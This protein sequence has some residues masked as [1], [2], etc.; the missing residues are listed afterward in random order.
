MVDSAGIREYVDRRL[1]MS[2]VRSPDEWLWNGQRRRIDVAVEKQHLC[3]VQSMLCQNPQAR[4]SARQALTSVL[5]EPASDAGQRTGGCE[6]RRPPSRRSSTSLRA[7]VLD[8]R[9]PSGLSPE[10]RRRALLFFARRHLDHSLR[11]ECFAEEDASSLPFYEREAQDARTFFDAG[12]PCHRVHVVK[13][14]RPFRLRLDLVLEGTLRVP[15]FRV[16][17]VFATPPDAEGQSL[18]V[19]QWREEGSIT[20]LAHLDPTQFASARLATASPH[21]APAN[22]KY[23]RLSVCARVLLSGESDQQLDLDDVVYCKVVRPCRQARLSK[24][25]GR[26]FGCENGEASST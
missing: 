7:Q 22:R 21:F 2:P 11:V 19:A 6:V 1:G 24:R 16:L 18:D 23:V 13:R 3:F 17:S 12:L 9:L 4:P 14:G 26:C 5:F 10:G 20:A 25:I 15:I 8:E